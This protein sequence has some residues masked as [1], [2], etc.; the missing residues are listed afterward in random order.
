M[1]GRVVTA[2][3]VAAFDERGDRGVERLMGRVGARVPPRHRPHLTLGAARVPEAR[4]G[5]VCDVA[6]GVAAAAAPFRLELGAVG[7]F[8]QGV[9]W[10]APRPEPELRRLQA[11]ADAALTAAGFARAFGDQA[12]PDRWVAH[13][14]LAT[15]LDP[16]ALG[17]AVTALTSGFRP[18]RT[19][20]V[21]LATILVGGRGDVGYAPLAA[22][23]EPRPAASGAG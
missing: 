3:V 2:V 6:A 11:G 18:V 5:E 20:V 10:L 14:T 17:T 4:V 8:P 12:A 23:T 22:A 15:R 21:A 7:I 13:C 9:L 19:R 1:A 16:P